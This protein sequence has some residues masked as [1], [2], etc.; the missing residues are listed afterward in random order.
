MHCKQCLKKINADIIVESGKI[1]CSTKCYG[2]Y[3]ISEYK[4]K[5]DLWKETWCR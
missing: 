1:F 3:V 5:I 2:K 4:R